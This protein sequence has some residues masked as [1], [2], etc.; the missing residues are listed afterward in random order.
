[1]LEKVFEY[2][3]KMCS[4]QLFTLT[5]SWENQLDEVSKKDMIESIRSI[6]YHL[7]DQYEE[8]KDEFKGK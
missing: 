1:M 5:H 8:F 6:A 7:Q 4:K 3:T 2:N